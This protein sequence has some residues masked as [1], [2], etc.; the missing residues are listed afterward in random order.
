MSQS[1]L[2]PSI[3]QGMSLIKGT[4]ALAQGLGVSSQQVHPLAHPR[5]PVSLFSAWLSEASF[6]FLPGGTRCRQTGMRDGGGTAFYDHVW[7]RVSVSLR[8]WGWQQQSHAAPEPLTSVSFSSKK[9]HGPSPQFT[10]A[11][12]RTAL[13]KVTLKASDGTQMLEF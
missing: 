7:P 3:T 13:F 11:Q 12:G 6:L 2:A 1:A 5:C 4:I 8:I 9:V 10:G